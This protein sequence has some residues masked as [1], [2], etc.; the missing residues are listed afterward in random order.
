[1][2]VCRLNPDKPARRIDI[3]LFSIDNFYTGLLYFTGSGEHN[4]QMR[5]IALEKGYKLSEF[6][7]YPI[8]L[9]GVEGEPVH[10][11]CEKDVFD[12]LQIPYREP[13][14]RDFSI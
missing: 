8:G 5:I 2:G 4:R 3:T 9:T 11:T 7:L 13:K 12:I 6:G 10:I 14:D 1:M